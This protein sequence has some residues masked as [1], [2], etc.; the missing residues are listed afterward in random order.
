MV[1]LG[2]GRCHTTNLCF[3]EPRR[4][5][6]I[7]G[8][9]Q[10]ISAIHRRW[11]HSRARSVL[12][13]VAI[14]FP[15]TH[16]F[17]PR[18]ELEDVIRSCETGK[19]EVQ[20]NGCRWAR[21]YQGCLPSLDFWDGWRIMSNDGPGCEPR[22]KVQVLCDR[23]CPKHEA[24]KLFR[25]RCHSI[26]HSLAKMCLA[27]VVCGMRVWHHWGALACSFR[28]G[29]AMDRAR[30]EFCSLRMFSRV[31]DMVRIT[32]GVFS[33]LIASCSGDY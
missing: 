25:Y 9:D 12:T 16:L 1:V 26:Y 24:G 23:E 32:L 2:R 21:K 19:R 13:T 30:L 7:G 27:R 3:R 5:Q 18:S 31:R 8:Q 4:C 20:S 15:I 17:W 14:A 22:L 10:Q 33:I 29:A 28:I 11:R 6:S